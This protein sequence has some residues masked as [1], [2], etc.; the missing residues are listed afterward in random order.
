MG[1]AGSAVAVSRKGPGRV[2][3]AGASRVR[4]AALR[5]L[6]S[7]D[8]LSSLRSGATAAGAVALDALG[9]DEAMENQARQ[10]AQS[11]QSV[12]DGL[13]AKGYKFQS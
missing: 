7:R 6:G 11:I 2:C 12:F 9:L 10:V 5:L 4:M 8:G 1:N 13:V 3:E